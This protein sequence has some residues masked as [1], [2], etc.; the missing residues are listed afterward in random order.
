MDKLEE[1]TF[2]LFD[3]SML[4]DVTIGELFFKHTGEIYYKDKLLTKDKEIV[5]ALRK[6]L[7]G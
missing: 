2:D 3:S 4:S 6:V 5:D 7:L 1:W